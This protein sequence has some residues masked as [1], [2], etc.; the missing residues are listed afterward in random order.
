MVV[1]WDELEEASQAPQEER[2]ASEVAE[3]WAQ[4]WVHTRMEV[5]GMT[6]NRPNTE[7]HFPLRQGNCGSKLAQKISARASTRR[8][9]EDKR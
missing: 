4:S 1:W 9:F 5:S 6:Y 7:T 8:G 3:V 2:E